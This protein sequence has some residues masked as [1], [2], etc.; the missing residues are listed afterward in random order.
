MIG[1][2]ALVG[3]LALDGLAAAQEDT[4]AARTYRRVTSP[5]Q[6]V[7]IITYTQHHND[8]SAMEAPGT[9]LSARPM[10]GTVSIRPDSVVTG[11]SRFGSRDCSGKLL[12]GLGVFYLPE[13][14]YQGVDR[15]AVDVVNRNGSAHDTVIVTVR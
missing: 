5:G 14:G 6:E 3:C 15:F 2:V 4:A 11:P 10:H 8:C 7:R 12:P 13:P 9:T 1:L